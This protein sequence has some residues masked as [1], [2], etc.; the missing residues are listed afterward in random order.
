MRLQIHTRHADQKHTAHAINGSKDVVDKR[1]GKACQRGG[2]APH[3]GSSGRAG[4]DRV[5]DKGRRGAIEVAAAL[6]LGLHHG[7]DG[8]GLG[9]PDGREGVAGLEGGDPEEGADAEGEEG[10]DDHQVARQLEPAARGGGH[11]RDGQGEGDEDHDG[12][13]YARRQR[14]A[15][16]QQI[17]RRLLALGRRLVAHVLHHY[18]EAEHEGAHEDEEEV[19]RDIG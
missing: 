3:Q 11:G 9:A 18:R 19:G 16:V 8:G 14:E 5:G 4:A 7:L 13:D 17:P 12:V 1:V 2:T 10:V 6:E 15:L